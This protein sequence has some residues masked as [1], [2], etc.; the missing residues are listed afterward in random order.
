MNKLELKQPFS[1]KKGKEINSLTIVGVSSSLEGSQKELA[2][3]NK[4]REA[5]NTSSDFEEYCR[6]TGSI[7]YNIAGSAG[8]AKDF[9]LGT[10]FTLK[11][12]KGAKK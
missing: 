7:E 10:R 8:G 2:L 1:I 3:C 12:E 4:F 6:N 11:C 5:F 9:V